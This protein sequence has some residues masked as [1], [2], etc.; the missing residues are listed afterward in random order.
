M[1]TSYSSYYFLCIDIYIN[2]TPFFKTTLPTF[3]TRELDKEEGTV[4]LEG[5]GNTDIEELLSK[6]FD[7]YV[8]DSTK[9]GGFFKQTQS[10]LMFPYVEKRKRYD[11]Y[12]EIMQVNQFV[13]GIGDENAGY[14]D[15]N[16]DKADINSNK[17]EVRIIAF[18]LHYFGI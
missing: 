3:K 14:G 18:N 10:Y 12:R 17:D 8:R 2:Y 1:F 4:P 15:V 5:I 11:N 16:G 9:Y 7:L 13:R 6:H